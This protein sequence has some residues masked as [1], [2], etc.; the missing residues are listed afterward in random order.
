MEFYYLI[1]YHLIAE[2]GPEP[3]RINFTIWSLCNISNQMK[4][5]KYLNVYSK[6]NRE[7]A[8]M[9]IWQSSKSQM[10]RQTPK[11]DSWSALQHF[12][13]SEK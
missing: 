13:S 10:F 11:A 3:T 9:F 2:S 1:I 7:R 6:R 4:Q 12:D 8:L 5:A